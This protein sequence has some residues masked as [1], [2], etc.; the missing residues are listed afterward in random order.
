MDE[1]LRQRALSKE[2]MMRDQISILADSVEA[3]LKQDIIKT[4]F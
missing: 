4:G 1:D 2:M 3:D